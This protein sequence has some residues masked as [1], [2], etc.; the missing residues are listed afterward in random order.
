M[1]AIPHKRNS[2][3]CKVVYQLTADTARNSRCSKEV[4]LKSKRYC[5]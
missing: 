5:L 2:N 3:K 1:Y 4:R